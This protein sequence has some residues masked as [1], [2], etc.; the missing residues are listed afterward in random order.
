MIYARINPERLRELKF[1]LDAV[2]HGV[3]T[4]GYFRRLLRVHGGEAKR[5]SRTITFQC[6]FNDHSSMIGK[7]YADGSIRMNVGEPYEVYI[8]NYNV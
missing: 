1:G 8:P 4:S 7:C 5:Y 2:Y 3:K 6:S